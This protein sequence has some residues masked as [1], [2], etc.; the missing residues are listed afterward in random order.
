MSGPR[1][2]G[3]RASSRSAGRL[4]LQGLRGEGRDGLAPE[5]VVLKFRH[6]EDILADAPRGLPGALPAPE[7]LVG[8]DGDAAASHLVRHTAA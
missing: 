4:L 1:M 6:S 2:T 7:R 3:L 8:E 5:G